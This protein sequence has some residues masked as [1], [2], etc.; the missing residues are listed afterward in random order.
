MLTNK[1]NKYMIEIIKEYLLPVY[2]NKISSVFPLLLQQT[3]YIKY[4]LNFTSKTLKIFHSKRMDYWT[5]VINHK[6]NNTKN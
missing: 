5:I 6:R 1:V 2:T 4:G 3:F